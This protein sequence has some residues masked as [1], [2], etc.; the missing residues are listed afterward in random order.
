MHITQS[1]L[2]HLHLF[3]SAWR[4]VA[5]LSVALAF[6]LT[7]HVHSGDHKTVGPGNGIP[8]HQYSKFCTVVEDA[9]VQNMLQE[10]CE[11]AKEEMK[12]MPF[13]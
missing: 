11:G 5:P 8:S 9:Y 13:Q 4:Y 10:I 1:D 3:C 2:Q 7:G 12:A 6:L